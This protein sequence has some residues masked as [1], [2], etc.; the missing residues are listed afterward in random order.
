MVDTEKYESAL[1]I[2]NFLEGHSSVK[3][4]NFPGLPSFPQYEL[5]Q[6]QMSG[7]GGLFSIVLDT[8]NIED[9]KTFVNSLSLFQIGVS[10]GGHESLVYAPVISYK[11]EL[12]REQYE[13]FGIDTGL[14]RL[15]I[16]LESSTDLINDLSHALS[17]SR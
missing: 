11:R 17:E 3:K 10:W 16:G 4:V 1:L 7:Y 14:V 8:D 9:V 5:G 13:A 6:K 12:T 2:A 15:S